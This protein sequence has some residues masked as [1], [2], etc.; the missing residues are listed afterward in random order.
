MGAPRTQEEAM[1]MRSRLALVMAIAMLAVAVGAVTAS[2]DVDRYQGVDY[3]LTVTE[4]NDNTEYAHLFHI[5][6]D[7]DLVAY[8]GSGTYSNGTKT[9]SLS[10]FE[11]TGG[12]F[13]FQSDYDNADYTWFPAFTLNTDGTLTF[14]EV[15][16]PPIPPGDN[17]FAAEGTWTA[18]DTE[19]KNHGQYVKDAVDKKAAAHSLIGMPVQSQTKNK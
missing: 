6:Q 2:A 3:E 13:S 18:T 4:V 14:V 12:M 10:S 9:E 7:P 15:A 5:L 17:V 19:Y 11:M 1:R 16:P 8:T